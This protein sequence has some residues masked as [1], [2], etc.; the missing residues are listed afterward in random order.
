MLF[1][2]GSAAPSS[3]DAYSAQVASVVYPRAML[4]DGL[5]AELRG[6][7]EAIMDSR[8][9]ASS[10]RS[11]QSAY[12]I[13]RGVAS[14]YGWP[15]VI[16]TDDPTRGGKLVAFVMH[17]LEDTELVAESIGTYV[18]G[19]RWWMKLQHQ[20][21]PAL[22]VMGWHDFMT[23][24]RVLAHVPHEP[25][26]AIPL[27]LVV[28]MAEAANVDCF[29]EVQFIFFVV[30]L[31]FTFSRAECPC[32]KSFEGRDAW[33]DNKH[34]MVRDL[35]IRMVDGRYV[36]AV[37]FKA[38]KQDGRIERPEARGDGTA[39]RGE[40]QR[41]GSDWSYVGDIPG[42]AL[43]PFTWYRR[44]MA[45]YTGPRVATAPFFVA[46][47]RNRPYTYRTA[48]D[49]LRVML[50]RVSPSDT[51]FSLHGL[52][53]EGYN[54][55]KARSSED[56]AVAHGGWQRGSNTRYDRFRLRDV[57]DLS[58][59][60]VGA[61]A[62]AA[63]LPDPAPIGVPEVG[64]TQVPVRSISPGRASRRRT[65]QSGGEVAEADAAPPEADASQ[66]DAEEAS[67]G[68]GGSDGEEPPH[69]AA[70]RRVAQVARSPMEAARRVARA[71]LSRVRAELDIGPDTVADDDGAAPR[72]RSRA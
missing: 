71:A 45:F 1:G 16:A 58:S 28:S 22:G 42:H 36:L 10:M 37:R 27:A 21:D 26:R 39:P 14:R 24:V 46:R 30:V 3:R 49:D 17:M 38:I 68:G 54:L 72:T 34:W 43:S 13:W 11:V 35:V 41:G 59:A 47:D 18:W 9:A 40:A 57:F 6:H 60:M 19:L 29:W 20:A 8:L 52:R 23:S 7:A 48:L 44:L 66:A 32:P 5:P 65:D 56:L 53:V 62:A 55:A 12:G 33:D 69:V 25:R 63:S 67:P 50:Q 4:F 64:E 70:A 15:E 2:G 61:S 51:D 31:L